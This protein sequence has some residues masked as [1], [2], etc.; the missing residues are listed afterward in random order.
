MNYDEDYYM[1]GKEKGIS[2]YENYRWMPELTMP[3]T[4]TIINHLGIKIR[5]TVLDFGCARGYLVKALRQ[6]Q[7]SSFGVDCS[8]W[9]IKNC[10]SEIKDYVRCIKH[11]HQL[12]QYDWIIAKDVLEH[13]GDLNTCIVSLMSSAVKGIFV[14]VPLV[15]DDGSYEVPEY[16]QDVTHIHRLSLNGWA[17]KFM[18]PGWAVTAQYRLPGVKDNYSQYAWGNGFIT[19]RRI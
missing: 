11:F 10:D 17:E 7:M 2:L 4:E 6:Y 15:G 14:V 3:M 8:E 5:D 13:I 9:A 1:R 18:G 19:C 12:G 16:E